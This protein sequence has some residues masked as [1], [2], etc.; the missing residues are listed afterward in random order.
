MIFI[1]EH[2][3]ELNGIYCILNTKSN[4]FYIGLTKVSFKK[5]FIQH[6]SNLKNNRHKNIYLQRAFNKYGKDNFQFIILEVLN[7]KNLNLLKIKEIEHIKLFESYKNGYN[8]TK[9]GDLAFN[10]KK[11]YLYK[12]NK[13]KNKITFQFYKKYDFLLDLKYDFKL[14]SFRSS[15][16]SGKTGSYKLKDFIIL[17][18]DEHL[19][20]NKENILMEKYWN[21]QKIK[22]VGFKD[23]TEKLIKNQKEAISNKIYQISKN[24]ELIKIYDSITDC[25]NFFNI[26]RDTIYK[27][28][29]KEKTNIK[30][31]NSIFKSE[32]DVNKKLLK[33]ITII[34]DKYF[35]IERINFKSINLFNLDG[36]FIKKFNSITDCSKFLNVSI[37]TVSSC[38]NG[39]QKTIKRK[40]IVKDE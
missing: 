33:K 16:V 22:K 3:K 2:L 21:K 13:I 20:S 31:F 8:L 23:R 17:L 36:S 19:K 39:H 28:I 24:N 4:K 27:F 14:T 40:Y 30:I 11:L 18:E 25:A 9:G 15:I 1:N 34:D 38:L 26:S 10:G 6:Q 7:T 29:N 5:R 37:G 35:K 32:K 12:I